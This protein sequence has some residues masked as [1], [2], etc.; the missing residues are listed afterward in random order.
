[1]NEEIQSLIKSYGMKPH[2][3]GGFYIESFKSTI[4]VTTEAGKLRYYYS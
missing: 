4:I 1:M 3:E 2:P